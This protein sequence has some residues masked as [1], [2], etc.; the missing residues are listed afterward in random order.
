MLTKPPT[1]QVTFETLHH[2]PF[3]HI[4][5]LQ[6]LVDDLY[7]LIRLEVSGGVPGFSLKRS[8][9]RELFLRVVCTIYIHKIGIYIYIY[10]KS[11]YVLIIHLPRFLNLFTC[12]LLAVSNHFKHKY[13]SMLEHK[14]NITALSVQQVVFGQPPS[15]TF[16]SFIMLF[17]DNLALN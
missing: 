12:F 10:V 2:G 3:Q 14:G 11:V 15:L 5:I 9:L 17:P 13:F 1:S 4:A 16:V 6:Q 8:D 7:R